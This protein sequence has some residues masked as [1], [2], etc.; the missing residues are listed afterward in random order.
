[1]TAEQ[2]RAYIEAHPYA[3]RNEIRKACN[4][5]D[6]VLKRLESQGAIKLPPPMNKSIAATLGRKKRK[7]A[8]SWYINRKPEWA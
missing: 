3:S 2:I 7:V 5:S 6:S 4:T 1:M 8:E